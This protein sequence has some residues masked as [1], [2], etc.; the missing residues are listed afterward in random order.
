MIAHFS[1]TY[2]IGQCVTYVLGSYP[3]KLEWITR[4]MHMGVRSRVTRA[5]QMLK[6]KLKNKRAVQKTWQ[7]ATTSAKLF[8]PQSIALTDMKITSPK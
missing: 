1:V 8:I 5:E 6:L 3:V 7:K 2:V 4:E